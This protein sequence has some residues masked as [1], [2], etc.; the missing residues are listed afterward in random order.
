MKHAWNGYVEKGWTWNEVRPISGQGY[1]AAIFGNQKT[2]A[3]I[4]DALDTLYIMGLEDEFKHG[5]SYFSNF[6]KK[7]LTKKK[8]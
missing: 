8:I 1:S 4:V 5:S 7:I 2:G 3:T 6:L